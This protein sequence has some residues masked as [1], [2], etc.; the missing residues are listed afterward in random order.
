MTS[1]PRIIL[2]SGV[3]SVVLGFLAGFLGG[4]FATPPAKEKPV[5]AVIQ[6]ERFQLTDSNGRAR[7]QFEVDSQGVAR[8]VLAGQDGAPLVR[9]SA[10]LQGKTSL[11]MGDEDS[12]RGVIVNTEPEGLQ[13]IALYSEG[14]SRLA[15]EVQKNGDPAINLNDKGKRLITLG[16]TGQGDPHLAFYGENQKVALE[17]ISKKN[18]D[19]SLTLAGKDGIP[20]VVLGLKMDQ[21]AALGLFDR[22][23]K[24]RAALMDEPSLLL[25][26]NGKVLRTL[27]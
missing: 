18:G 13:T 24:T 27:P 9:L 22:N 6:A 4:K 3:I 5:S 15:L 2:I 14:K 7:G 12:Q 23:G 10:N 21:K 17:V 1:Q 8:L 16:L 19:R 20:R 26:K 25:L 11:Q